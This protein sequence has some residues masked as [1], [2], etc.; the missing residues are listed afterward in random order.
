MQIA[1]LGAQAP[2]LPAEVDLRRADVG[3]LLAQ[4]EAGSVDLVVADPPWDAYRER[5]G[6][7][8]PDG[9]YGLLTERQIGDHLGAAVERMRPGGR[10]ALWACWPL[11]VE[12]LGRDLPPW[13]TIPGLVWKSGGAWSKSGSAPGV[14]YH[15]RGK[16]EPVLVGVREGGAAGRARVVLRSGYTSRPEAHSRKPVAWMAD[17]IRAWVPPGGLVLDLYAGLGSVAE[18]V[19]EAGEGRRYVGAEVDVDR[20]AAAL[21]NVRRR[22]VGGAS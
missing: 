20:H 13:L 7:V 9:V 10:L 11:L 8:A 2:E 4:V 12:A 22:A 19:V 15:W 17:W 14:G 1:L 21:A 6:V 5:P 16:S 18:A 3:D